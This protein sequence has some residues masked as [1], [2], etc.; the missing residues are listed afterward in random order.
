ML[1]RCKILL[2]VVPVCL[3]LVGGFLTTPSPARAQEI[4]QQAKTFIDGLAGDAINALTVPGS[5][6]EQREQ[7]E[8]SSINLI[9]R[10]A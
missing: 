9:R 7:R 3:V 1:A 6:E 5:T 2:A 4:E 10:E 8:A